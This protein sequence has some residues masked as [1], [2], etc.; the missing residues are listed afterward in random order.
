MVHAMFVE[1]D[2]TMAWRD[3]PLP[4]LGEDEIAI[5]VVAAGV[6]R[7]D[8]FQRAG[9]YPPPPGASAALGLEVCGTVAA[10]GSK[11]SDH[12]RVGDR[13]MALVPGGGYAER[14][15]VHHGSV[16]EWPNSLKPEQAAGFCE[17]AFTVWT[18]VFQSGAL[19]DGERLFVHGATSGIG[20]MAAA[21]AASRG[22]DVY[23]TAGTGEKVKAGEAAG[24]TTVW[25]YK[26]EAWDD[27]M[28]Q[29]GGCDVVLDMVGGSYITRN[30]NML[31]PGGRNVMI[32][33]LGGMQAEVN[34]AMVMQKNLTLTGSTL[35][36][37]SAAAKQSLRDAVRE[38]V[39]PKVKTGDV[40]PIVGLTLPMHK[41]DEAHRALEAG[42]VIGKVI[43]MNE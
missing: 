32:A 18:N 24:F 16:L 33:F 36:A 14:C 5:D 30:F 1:A 26:S 29:L 10:A 38:E 13:V 40:K 7:P 12:W 27:E 11:A 37:R 35:R 22:H 15:H 41:A 23:G 42:E 43:L 4:T 6:N 9:F 17:T 39:M 8:L 19:Q 31:R 20:T 21:L 3:E 34:L 2:K 28:T 25:N